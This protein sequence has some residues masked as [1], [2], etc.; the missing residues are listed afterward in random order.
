M[1]NSDESKNYYFQLSEYLQIA[2][3]GMHSVKLNVMENNS[4]IGN[5]TIENGELL[6]AYDNAG[7]GEDAFKRL[8][9]NKK[10]EVE[11]KPLGSKEKKKNIEINCEELIFR[12][13]TNKD[14]ERAL[15]DLSNNEEN[16]L[17]PVDKK[18]N[19]GLEMLIG[20]NYQEARDLFVEI[21]N[22][23]PGIVKVQ[24]ILKRLN[25]LL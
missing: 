21:N 4:L 19:S 14:K 24:E 25:E 12:I 9:L 1:S 3:S 5:I 8:I 18:I 2:C 22:K 6:N 15:A 17:S 13:F 11:L 10:A 7:E 16:S 20:K 23:S